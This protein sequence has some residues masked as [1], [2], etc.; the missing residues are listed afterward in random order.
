MGCPEHLSPFGSAHGQCHHNGTIFITVPLLTII[1]R[2]CLSG[3]MTDG[4]FQMMQWFCARLTPS[5]NTAL[6]CGSFCNS[7][8]FSPKYPQPQRSES[9]K[10]GY[11]LI[12]SKKDGKDQ[13]SIQSST[14]PDP[15]YQW[16][17]NKPTA[18]HHKG[19]LRS[20]DNLQIY[21][22][23]ASATLLSKGT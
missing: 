10:I 17:S 5:R 8:F 14:T 21:Y 13:K 9:K 22:S 4:V 23:S 18:R 19:E 2:H 6:G 16:E 11:W 7:A 3:L 15:G 1:V 12:Q 20:Q